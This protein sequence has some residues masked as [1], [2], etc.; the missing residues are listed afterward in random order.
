MVGAAET[1]DARR[2]QRLHLF[3]NGGG[4]IC[5]SKRILQSSS[6]TVNRDAIKLRRPSPST[7]GDAAVKH[8]FMWRKYVLSWPFH[9][10]YFLF[11]DNSL[12]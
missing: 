8:V 11:R 5:H 9:P 2:G 10:L 3:Q 4:F 12:S 1:Q 6:K 7:L